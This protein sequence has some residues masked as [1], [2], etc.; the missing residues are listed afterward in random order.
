MR[1]TASYIRVIVFLLIS[2]V[3][4]ESIIESGEESVFMTQPIAWLAMG[5]VLLF[6]IAIEICLE[7]LKVVLFKSLKPKAQER[8]LIAEQHRKEQQFRGV[9]NIYLKLLDSKP[10]EEEE[11]IILDHNYDGIK[12][13]DNNLPPWWVYGFYATILFGVIYLARFHVFNDYN[14]TEEYESEVAAALIAIEEYKKNAKDLVDANTVTIL[15]DVS[16]ISAGKTIFTAN[17]VACHKADGGG[18]IGPNLTDPY[19]ILG[20]GIKNVFQ[21]ISEGGR[22][23]KGMVAWKQTLKPAEMAQV[24]SYVMTLGG[25]TPV[26]PK[27]PQ[28]EVWS[29]PDTSIKETPSEETPETASDSTS[30][31]VNE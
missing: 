23:G 7:A 22:D 9:K 1:S 26:E 24:A 4:I 28:G 13:L 21:T 15:T 10:V 12:E 18:G 2:Y 14:Q 31:V 20:G 30:V 3:L 8:Y 16:D 6:A 11:E 25:T 27:E 17:C 29:D 19:W 5:I